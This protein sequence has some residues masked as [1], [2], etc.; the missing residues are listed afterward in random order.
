MKGGE[1][2]GESLKEKAYELKERLVEI[3]RDLHMNPELS[4]EEYETAKKI[5]NILQD[6]DIEVEENVGRTGIVGILRGE[7][8]SEDK[9]KVVALRGDIDALPIQEQNEVEY[10]SKKAGVMHA[11]GHDVHTT[12]L[13][14]AAMILSSVRDNIKGTVKFIFQPAEEKNQGAKDM[15]ADDVLKDPDVDCIF[16]LHTKPDIEVGKVGVKAG[17][18]MAA[19]DRMTITVRGEGGH[20]AIPESTRDSIVAASSLVQN[21]Q[22]IVSRN[23]SPFENIVVSIGTINGGQAWNVISDKVEMKGTVRSYNPELQKKIPEMM[24]RIVSNTCAALDTEGDVDY[25][26]DLPAVINDE[27]AA[28]IGKK[29]VEKIA[30]KEGTIVPEITGGG[31]DFAIYM[32]EVPGCFYFLG[33]RNEEKGIVYPW[34]HPKF[35]ADEKSLPIGAGVLAQSAFDY[36]QTKS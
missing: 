6:L 31:E 5:K 32:E 24:E 27:K 33:V 19:V 15:M 34:H 28:E 30:G 8:S 1:E 18:L 16:G 4:F 10:K 3:R 29:A 9:E 26:F 35:D 7:E 20:A 2:V 23:I 17:P 11:C 22:T 12:S 21:L 13:L 36:L 25:K 14:G